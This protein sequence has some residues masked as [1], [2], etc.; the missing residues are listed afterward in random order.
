MR[1]SD[2]VRPVIVRRKKVVASDH[3]GGAWKVALAD[4]ST[5][6][7]AFFLMLWLLGS[8]SDDQRKGLADYFSQTY[9]IESHSSGGEGVMGGESLSTVDSL[10]DSIATRGTSPADMQVLEELLST[11]ERAAQEAGHGD[12]FEHVLL[13]MSEEGLVVELFDLDTA[14]LFHPETDEPEPVLE[15]L[16]SILGEAFQTVTNPLAIGAYSRSFPLVIRENPVWRLT[17]ARAQAVH[18]MFEGEGLPEPRIR[19]VTGNA[20]RNPFDPDPMAVRNNRVELVLLRQTSE[21]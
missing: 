17:V 16:V 7:M 10:T 18:R 5:A 6:M 20:D 2:E 12:A 15:F 4:F 19:S 9:A 11:L 8:V 21:P 13:R 14:P 3:H 1:R